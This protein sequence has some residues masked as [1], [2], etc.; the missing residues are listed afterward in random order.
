MRH[1]GGNYNPA[2]DT[3]LTGT[4]DEVRQMPAPGRGGGGVHLILSAAAGPVEVHVGAASFVTAKHITFAKG[5]ALT[6][7]GSKVMMAAKATSTFEAT[8][9]ASVGRCRL[10]RM[11]C[12]APFT[13]RLQIQSVTQRLHEW[14]VRSRPRCLDLRR[15]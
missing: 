7:V 14:A 4:V 3:T 12:V 8:K 9:F 6:V 1:G 13:R 2:T 10:A 15:A 5:D 11:C